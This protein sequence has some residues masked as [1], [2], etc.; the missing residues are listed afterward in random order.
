MPDL[1]GVARLAAAAPA[2]DRVSCREIV[3]T[4]RDLSRSVRPS[5]VA[6]RA[7]PTPWRR[8]RR[9]SA[10]SRALPR[11]GA[12]TSTRPTT[13]ASATSAT[14][15]R[16]AVPPTARASRRAPPAATPTSRSA[17]TPQTWC[18]CARASC[19]ASRR[20]PSACSTPAASSTSRSASRACSGSPTAARRCCASTTCRSGAAAGLDAHD[21]RGPRRAAAA[22]PRRHEVVLLRHRGGAQP[23]LPR[24]RARL[25]GLRRLEQAGAGALR[26]AVL[27]PH[28]ARGRWTRWGSSARTWSATRWA[29]ASRSRSGCASPT[30]SAASRCCAPRSRSCAAAAT[31]SCGSLRPELGLLPHSL[32]R[33]R[34]ERQFWSMFADRDL[35]DPSVADIVV[36]EFERIYRSAGARL[37]FLTSARSI[38][39]DPPFGRGGPLP[40][41]GGA[42]AAG[43]VRVGLARQADPARLQRHVERWL[44]DAE[45]IVLEG[46]GHVPQVERPERT[47]GLLTRFFARID[48]LGAATARC[49]PPP[50]GRRTSTAAG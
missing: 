11:R 12:A 36:D 5:L 37:A 42:R 30:A 48:A 32:G 3:R 18:R 17:P 10:R 21:G 49:R 43:D 15:G 45:Q 35:V 1:A 4:E 23:P 7:V 44:P 40:A 50:E 47:N 38:Y 19:P 25:P 16:S 13:C 8:C 46:C 26:R 14:P 34:I 41:A 31:R 22:R 39:L 27:R 29:A 33:G 28:G 20:S 2:P 6:S 9:L 24:P